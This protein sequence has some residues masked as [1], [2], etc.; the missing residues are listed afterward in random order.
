LTLEQP[1]AALLPGWTVPSRNSKQITL[2]D[3]AEQCSGLP[4]LPT[5][6]A[7]A[8]EANPYADYDGEK[9]RA[10]LQGYALTRDPGE[11]YEYSNLG[12]GV[13]AFALA[14]HSH[15]SYPA[16]VDQ[17]I[18]V[19]LQMNASSASPDKIQHGLLAAGHDEAG[20]AVKNWDFAAL[21]GAGA[22]RSSAADMLRYLRANM[23]MADGELGSAMK[24]AQTPRRDIGSGRRIGLAWMTQT[25]G[26]TDIIWHNGGTGGYRS[27]IGF[28]TDHK[29][30]V[31]ILTNIAYSVDDLGFATLAADAPLAPVRK[32]VKF[33]E[34][35]LEEYVGEYQL[36]ANFVLTIS[37][38][39][40]Q[41][42]AQATGQ[43]AF[44][45]YASEANEFFAKVAPISITFKR[46]GDGTIKGLVLHQNGDRDAP[47]LVRNK[48]PTDTANRG[49]DNIAALADYAGRYQF[50]PGAVLEIVVKQG[51]LYGQLNEQPSYPVYA[52]DRD[53]FRYQVVDAQLAFERDDHGRVIA[54]TLHQNGLDQR[55]SRLP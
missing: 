51:Q 28:T 38:V 8:D 17:R 14:Q 55:A 36:S 5:N 7:P 47:R 34:I 25:Q 21:A 32:S 27:F 53:K 39:G 24:L 2:L 50:A 43:G 26:R 16:L 45:I 1:V 22:I 18:F 3:L 29:R 41:L 31:V 33:D 40:T 30:G 46:D 19:P 49:A 6:L 4:R 42:Y 48:K 11:G 10:F 54:V 23:V 37:R 44:P 9:L 20:N 15:R 12:F 52:S 35:E 13:L